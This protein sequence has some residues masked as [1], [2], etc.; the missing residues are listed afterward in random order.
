MLFSLSQVTDGEVQAHLAVDLDA[1]HLLAGEVSDACRLVIVMLD[2]EAAH[3]DAF[4]ALGHVYGIQR[5][6]RLRT[7]RAEAVRIEVR[8]NIDRVP[9]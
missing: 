9:E 8:M 2:D 5:A 7:M 6:G 1:G 3:A 4:R